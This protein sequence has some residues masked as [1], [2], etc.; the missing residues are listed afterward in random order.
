MSNHLLT[1]CIEMADFLLLLHNKN[2]MLINGIKLKYTNYEDG[3][4]RKSTI[5]SWA[6]DE[7]EFAWERPDEFYWKYKY[8]RSDEKIF[9]WISGYWVEINFAK[10]DA[11]L[12]IVHDDLISLS[13]CRIIAFGKNR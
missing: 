9:E 8:T 12:Q 3:C 13:S 10:L 11:S 2:N 6:I 7:D 1:S 5:I 4:Y